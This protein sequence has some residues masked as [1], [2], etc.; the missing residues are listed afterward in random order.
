RRVPARAFGLYYEIGEMAL[1][2]DR[3][4]A[5]ARAGLLDDV[6]DAGGEM[7]L[8]RWGAPETAALVEQYC[9]REPGAEDRFAEVSEADRKDFA[10]ALRAGLDLLEQG[11]P[12]LAGEIR[13]IVHEV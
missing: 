7:A 3:D 13:A 10:P 6:P 12:E 8:G 1:S 5:A 11:A 2:G 9:R 4:A